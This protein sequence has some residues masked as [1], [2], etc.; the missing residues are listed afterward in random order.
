M[1]NQRRTGTVEDNCSTMAVRAY[2]TGKE[3]NGDYPKI[4]PETIDE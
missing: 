2:L 1:K 3:T 4:D